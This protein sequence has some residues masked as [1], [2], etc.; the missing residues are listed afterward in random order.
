MNMVRMMKR[1]RMKSLYAL[2]AA[3]LAAPALAA[4]T[5]ALPADVAAYLE[6]DRK[7]L[8]ERNKQNKDVVD[9]LVLRVGTR[10]DA[11]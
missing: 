3:L 5:A 10:G 9:A 4:E 8:I 11:I 2:T 1:A 6:R 7:A